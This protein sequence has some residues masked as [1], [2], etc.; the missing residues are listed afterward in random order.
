MES[1]SGNW[2]IRLGKRCLQNNLKSLG[3]NTHIHEEL[4][5]PVFWEVLLFTNGNMAAKWWDGMRFHTT[6]YVHEKPE[7]RWLSSAPRFSPPVQ[8]LL[9]YMVVC[10]AL[11]VRSMALWL[12]RLFKLS[13]REVYHCFPVGHRCNLSVSSCIL[14]RVMVLRHKSPFWKIRWRITHDK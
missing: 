3:T 9:W 4:C 5:S 11:L 14:E 7:W 8:Y 10:F 2:E 6:W 12:S 1:L 13:I